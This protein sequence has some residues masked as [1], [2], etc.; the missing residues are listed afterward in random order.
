MKLNINSKTAQLY[1][2]FYGTSRMPESLCPYFWKL[3]LMWFFIVPYT[4]LSLPV[5]LMDLKDPEHRTTGE[6]AGFGFIIWFILFMLICMLSWIGVFFAEPVKD[7]VWMYIL[8]IGL[9]GWVA[10]IIFGGIALF[11]WSKEKWEN[12][13]IK[14]DSDGYRIWDEPI[15]KQPSIITE[16]VKA[17]YNKY[18]P[19]IDWK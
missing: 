1:R 7:S 8:S 19:K 5:I 15:E 16:F 11:K 2:W 17:K 6:R 4:I 18:C 10:A 9:L 14:Y 3:A 12:R 13:H